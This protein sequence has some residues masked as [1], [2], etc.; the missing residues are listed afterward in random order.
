MDCDI[1]PF[2]IVIFSNFKVPSFSESGELS[3]STGNRRKICFSYE[4]NVQKY[5]RKLL[6]S[7]VNDHEWLLKY[8]AHVKH[9]KNRR[10]TIV[11]LYLGKE[12]YCDF[13]PIF[14]HRVDIFLSTSCFKYRMSNK[15]K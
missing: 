3:Q 13:F 6:V 8:D 10:N 12:F 1:S 15:Q 9:F 2:E 5:F 7:V 4:Q 14:C 11:F